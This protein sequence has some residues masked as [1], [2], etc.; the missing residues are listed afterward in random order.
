ML[1]AYGAVLSYVRPTSGITG[2]AGTSAYAE[3]A[4]RDAEA[5]VRAL[6]GQERKGH[7]MTMAVTAMA[8]PDMEPA[9]RTAQASRPRRTVLAPSIRP[10]RLS[11][12][13]SR[14]KPSTN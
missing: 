7:F 8:A 2:R 4:P 6:D 10:A 11:A 5:A 13:T 12:P 3:M 9:D 1:K 14:E